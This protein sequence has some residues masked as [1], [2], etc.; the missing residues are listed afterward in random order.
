MPEAAVINGF[1]SV[2]KEL[3]IGG[4]VAL[5]AAMAF[6]AFLGDRRKNPPP[7]PRDEKH[8]ENKGMAR[9]ALSVTESGFREMGRRFDDLDS[10]LERMHVLGEIIKDR[11]ER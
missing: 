11:M 8:D 5:L 4:I 1:L 10:R 3:G 2:W 9:Q 7:A 6:S